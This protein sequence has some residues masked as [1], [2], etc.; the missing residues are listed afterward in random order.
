MVHIK[1]GLSTAVASAYFKYK[2]K[3]V[4]RGLKTTN[5]YIACIHYT[6]HVLLINV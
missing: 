3:Y 1:S 6:E 5:N 4:E 2:N